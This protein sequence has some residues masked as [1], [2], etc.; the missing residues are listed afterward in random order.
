M[1][2]YLS[3]K[4]VWIVGLFMFALGLI[5]ARADKIWNTTTGDWSEPAN[6]VGGTPV[7]GDAV[8]IIN[9]GAYV[10]LTNS[11]PWLSSMVISN[12]TL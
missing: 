11:T 6:W 4:R 1:H 10:Y 3:N 7:A 5:T 12:A 8:V 9:A 2:M